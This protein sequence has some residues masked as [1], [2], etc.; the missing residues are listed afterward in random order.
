MGQPNAPPEQLYKSPAETLEGHHQSLKQF[1]D[2][3]CAQQHQILQA[4]C[5]GDQERMFT[6]SRHAEHTRDT[7]AVSPQNRTL[8]SVEIDKSESIGFVGQRK[9]VMSSMVQEILLNLLC[10]Q[11]LWKTRSQKQKIVLGKTPEVTRS[12]VF[13]VCTRQNRLVT[14]SEAPLKEL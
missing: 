2:Q 10:H 9:K 13:L 14:V 11:T 8:A 7:P 5:P 3:W 12:T 4:F 6:F 1:I